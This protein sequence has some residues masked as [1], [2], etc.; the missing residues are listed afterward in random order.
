MAAT[1]P[2]MRA[3]PGPFVGKL[4]LY[5]MGANPPAGGKSLFRGERDSMSERVSRRAGQSRRRGR[6]GMRSTP[7][8]GLL[9]ETV[10]A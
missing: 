3:P 9:T 8:Q 10:A 5:L 7:K 4:R 2:K 6:R 1:V